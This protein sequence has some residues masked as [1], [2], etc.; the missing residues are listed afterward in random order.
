MV[1]IEHSTLVT[2]IYVTIFAPLFSV[3]LE[4]LLSRHRS[5]IITIQKR[6]DE[7]IKFSNKYYMPLATLVGG[8][9]GETDPEYKVRPKILF[10]KLAMYLSFYK[11]FLDA[12]VGFSFPKETQESKVA[13]CSG[14][15]FMAINLLIFNDDRE[16]IERVIKYYNKKPDF[17]SFIENIETLPEY[18][19]FESICDKGE[20]KE[21]LYNYSDELR[22]SI[23]D[24]ITEEYKVWY[25]VEFRKKHIEKNNNKNAKDKSINTR[26]LH[27]DIYNKKQR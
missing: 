8:I 16:A 7:F 11:C 5:K 6:S 26:K 20:I 10:F 25:K 23:L 1:T 21:M 3:L 17:L 12:G 2:L 24:G 9:K 4:L 27:K 19:T 18:S 22:N 15:F 14:T 13:L